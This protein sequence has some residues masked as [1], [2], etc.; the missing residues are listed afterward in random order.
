[1]DWKWFFGL[2]DILPGA[3][4]LV[5]TNSVI[6][7]TGNNMLEKGCLSTHH[8]SFVTTNH[9]PL[10]NKEVWPAHEY[11]EPNRNIVLLTR[12]GGWLGG[13]IELMAAENETTQQSTTHQQKASHYLVPA[14]K[15]NIYE[16]SVCLYPVSTSVTSLA[17]KRLGIF[18]SCCLQWCLMMPKIV[19]GLLGLTPWLP[20]TTRAYLNSI[21]RMS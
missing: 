15:L 3:S 1:M 9:A 5:L 10:Q 12:D 7:I 11:R 19:I 8:P 6:I 21:K 18:K 16:C 4:L 13:V 20:V 14:R 17:P 2:S